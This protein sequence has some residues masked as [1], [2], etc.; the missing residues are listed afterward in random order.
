MAEGVKHREFNLAQAQSE[1]NEGAGGFLDNQEV[2]GRAAGAA[3]G[4]AAGAV[5][6]G[7]VGA[8]AGGLVGQA[9]GALIGA[10]AGSE[11]GHVEVVK[12][13]AEEAAELSGVQEQKTS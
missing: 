4:A 5:V 13:P 3:T 1:A 9:V 12:S 11:A 7:P 6:A 8:V 10:E 2:K